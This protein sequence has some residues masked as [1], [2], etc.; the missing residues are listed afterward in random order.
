MATG[1]YVLEVVKYQDNEEDG[2]PEFIHV[3]YM[4]AMFKTKRNAVSYYDRHNT[5]LRSLNAH[6]TYCSDWDSDTHLLYIVRED[7][8]INATIDCFSTGDNPIEKISNEQVS[9]EYNWLK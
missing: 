8:F 4:K 1:A 3:G 5:H 7:Y 2:S 6:N 9:L